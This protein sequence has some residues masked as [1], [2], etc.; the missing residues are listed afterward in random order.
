MTDLRPIDFSS[1]FLKYD[2]VQIQLFEICGQDFFLQC[3]LSTVHLVLN[4]W[5]SWVCIYL[6]DQ[7]GLEMKKKALNVPWHRILVYICENN[8]NCVS[9]YD[10]QG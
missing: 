3:E 7:A 6:I 4:Q 10:T 1:S 8:F 2:Y 5:L 9:H